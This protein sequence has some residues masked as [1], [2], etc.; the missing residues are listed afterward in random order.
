MYCKGTG[1]DKIMRS[2][3]LPEIPGRG[4]YL[5]L[6]CLH[7]MTSEWPIGTKSCGLYF[8][9]LIKVFKDNFGRPAKESHKM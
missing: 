2:E 7:Q 6:S 5:G 9:A 8:D 4:Y 1:E 3:D